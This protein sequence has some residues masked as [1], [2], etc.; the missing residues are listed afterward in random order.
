MQWNSTH[1][2]VPPYIYTEGA[3]YTAHWQPELITSLEASRLSLCR[4]WFTRL[5]SEDATSLGGRSADITVL[6]RTT[7]EF[8][9]VEYSIH[10]LQDWTKEC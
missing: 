1:D 9:P 10:H 5:P 2:D 3:P 4:A 7:N 6:T 8:P